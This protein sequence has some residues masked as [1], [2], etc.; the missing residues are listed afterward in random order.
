MKKDPKCYYATF[1]GCDPKK[2]RFETRIYLEDLREEL[3]KPTGQCVAAVVC[4]N[5]GSASEIYPDRSGRWA[6]IRKD[7]T[8]TR[9][10]NIFRDAYGDDIPPG[11]FVKVW[12]L[13]YLCGKEYKDARRSV[14]QI[15]VQNSPSCCSESCP[16][17]VVWFAWGPPDPD[18]DFLMKR[19]R[20]MG[21]ERPFF[22]D[23]NKREL[24]ERVPLTGADFAKHPIRD[25]EV[26]AGGKSVGEAVKEHLKSVFART[27]S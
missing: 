11:A 16:C 12:N 7:N 2:F 3:S 26:P 10:R 4:K 14:I 9:I 22:F 15:G 27:G 21:I 17:S 1:T 8:L 23:K 13:F 18:L 25:S 6:L 20:K 19:F 5:P 24:V